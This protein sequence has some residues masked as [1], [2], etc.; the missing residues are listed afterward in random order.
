MSEMDTISLAELS[1]LTGIPAPTFS[2]YVPL[3]LPE[4]ETRL[5]RQ[6]A[7]LT[8][9]QARRLVAAIEIHRC[10]ISRAEAA[11]K[12]R[13]MPDGSPYLSRSAHITGDWSL[14]CTADALFASRKP[15]QRAIYIPV[16][17]L[18]QW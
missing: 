1:R 4:V 7:S 2:G 14:L 12:A 9:Q 16:G 3:V 18:C 11:E 15:G 10:G 13:Q 17:E 6:G 5:G 8:L